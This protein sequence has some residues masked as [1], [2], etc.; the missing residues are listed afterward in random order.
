MAF[1]EPINYETIYRK[2]EVFVV[3][4]L[5]INVL[6][7]KIANE[8]CKGCI[9]KCDRDGRLSLLK[10]HR[11]IIS[12]SALGRLNSDGTYSYDKRNEKINVYCT[13]ANTN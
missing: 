7:N 10:D 12:S 8:C 1:I 2:A 6:D 9:N 3:L 4:E 5:N 13:A 11:I